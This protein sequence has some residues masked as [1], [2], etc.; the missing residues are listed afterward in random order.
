MAEP[1]ST[2]SRSLRRP[3]AAPAAAGPVTP[4]AARLF[5]ALRILPSHG[6]N[7]GWTGRRDRALLVLSQMAGLPYETIAELTVA[8]ISISAGT[9][10]IRTPGGTTIL[11]AEDDVLI[12]GPC[13]LARWVHALDLGSVYA[14]GRVAAAVIARAAPLVADSPHLCQGAMTVT[15]ATL[16]MPVLPA[17]DPWGPYSAIGSRVGSRMAVF[18]GPGSSASASPAHPAVGPRR[19]MAR[20]V[21]YQRS[22]LP[23]AQ[24][25]PA[26]TAG[27][28]AS[29]RPVT[30]PGAF[31]VRAAH[32]GTARGPSV[33]AP[34]HSTGDPAGRIPTQRTAGSRSGPAV[35]GLPHLTTLRLSRYSRADREHGTVAGVALGLEGRASQLLDRRSAEVPN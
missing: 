10:T 17:T 13:A 22:A 2:H 25:R 24:P 31:A 26:A 27:I 8:D 4:S 3:G 32:P 33:A 6:W 30:T 29:V 14:N 1:G 5:A 35:A 34:R 18:H 12:C 23:T 20:S 11:A 19:A 15:E 7:A 21:A 28:V 16:S 9:A